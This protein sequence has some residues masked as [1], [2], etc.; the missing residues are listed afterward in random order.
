MSLIDKTSEEYLNL[1]R[2]K[3][4]PLLKAFDVYKANVNYGIVSETDE[5]KANILEW[6]SKVLALDE[7]ALNNVP[8]VIAKYK[9]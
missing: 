7:T 6:Y 8:S 1:L 2:K 4:E 5:Q 3:R 9:E